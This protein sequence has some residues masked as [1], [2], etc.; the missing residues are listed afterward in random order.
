[1]NGDLTFFVTDAQSGRGVAL[2]IEVDDEHRCRP[3]SASDA[4]RLTAVVLLPTPPFWLATA[5]TLALPEGGGTAFEA[6]DLRADAFEA[7]CASRS[8][9]SLQ[10]WLL[11]WRRASA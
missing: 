6:A 8:V 10:P 2:R 5:M 9:A 4:P 1:M 7:R 3:S 11:L